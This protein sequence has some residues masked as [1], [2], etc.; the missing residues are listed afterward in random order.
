MD[1]LQID[2]PEDLPVSARRSEILEAIRDNQVVIIAGATGSGKTTQIPKMCLELGRTSI[3][4]TQPRRIAA[5]AVAERIAEELKVEL[6]SLVGYQVRFTDK[7]SAETK[8]KVMTDGILLNAMQ[9][10]RNLEQYDTVIIDE[11]HE[12]S[13]NIDFLLGYLKQLL[14]KR[15]DLKVIV[16]SAT[17]D[18][19]SF[20][21]H[22][23][24]APIIEVSGRTFPIEV[25][26]RPTAREV[27]D[28]TD[29]DEETTASDYID[30]LI[31]GLLELEREAEGDTLV[32]LSGESEIRDAQ[33]AIEGAIT[34]GR[35]KKGT[36]VLPLYGRLSADEQHRVFQPSKMVGLRRRVILATNVA[37][38][39][40]TIPNIK[41]VIDAGT[42]R[43]SRYSPKAKVQRLPIEAISQASANQRAGRSGRTSPGIVLRL[44]AEDDYNARPQ[45]TDPE[46]LRTNLASV[47]LQSANLGLGDIT[48]FPFIQPPD[49]RGVKDGLG[50]L[51]EL[52][53]I[54]DAKGKTIRL[55]A[56]GKNLARLPIEPRF[57]RMLLEA[58]E[59]NLVREVLVI[60]AGLTIQDPRERPLA[61][62]PQADLAHARFAD[63]TSDFLSLVNLWNYLEE[64][65]QKLSSSAF[66]RMCKA[67]YLNY[68]R[69]RE[70]HDLIRQLKSVAKPLGIVPGN[71]KVDPDGIHKALLAGLLSQIGLRQ[72]TEKK[73]ADKAKATD[74]KSK[75]SGE[76]LGSN[77]KKFVIFPGS[78]LAKKGPAAI[79]S[80]ELVE[81]SR[82]FARMNAA[83][84]PAWA[85][86]LA[87][88]LCK[89]SY[90]EPHWEKSQ[91]SVVAY[92]RVMLFGVPIVVSRRMQYSRIDAELCRDL[93]VR[94]ALVQGEWDAKLPF[95]RANR[96]LMKQL[97]AEAN[98]ARKPQHSPD[99]D[100]AFRFYMS[101][102]PSDVFSTRTF[103]GWWKRA[104]NDTPNLLTMTR[105]DL[106][107]AQIAAPDEHEHPTEWLH[108]GQQLKL[109]YRFDPAAIDD[110]VS[111]DVPLAVLAAINPDEFEWLVPG[112]RL[113]L[114]TE[115]IRSLPKAIRK[116]VVPA[117]DW[118]A[119][120]LAVLPAEPS[121]NI[122]VVLA[123]VLQQL[124]GTKVTAAD[125]DLSRLP[126]NLKMT[127]RPIDSAG[128]PLGLST[129][130]ATL[131]GKLAESGRGAVAQV[132]ERV[133]SPIE[134]DGITSW[135][136]DT[137][138]RSIESKHGSNIVRAFPALCV[139]K[140]ADAVAIRIFSTESEQAR[141]HRVGVVALLKKS[142]ASPAKYVEAHLSQ[143]EKLAIAGLPYPSFGAFI[144]DVIEAAA[145]LELGLV[146]PGGLIFT[147]TQFE[148]VRDAVSASIVERAFEVAT[149]VTKISGSL[150]DANKAISSVNGFDFLSVLAGEKAHI[151][152]L[153]QPKFVSGIGLARLPRLDVYLQAIKQRIE[154]MVDNPARDLVA[155]QEFE[156][157]LGLYVFAGGTLPLP[158]TAPEKLVSARW[159]LEEFRVS[160]FAQSLG[161]AETVSVQRIK[162][163]LS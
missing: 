140:N 107:G 111:V 147:R 77:G 27:H 137:L 92:E 48:Q 61:K 134:R 84:D 162:K 62:R 87:G 54:D 116:N 83:I 65:Q 97:E 67:E 70:W 127:Y 133:N 126:N 8:V 26:Y 145:D 141:H 122:A 2:Y 34:A 74:S 120:A 56:I 71:P 114:I 118:A 94:H 45:F 138:E 80:A 4:H 19:E 159:L 85:E 110:G 13:L 102:I 28:D 124:S 17:I 32:F 39:S 158:I 121:G 157:A 6:G 76:Y 132:I 41:Y 47:I 24:N 152:E 119:K 1:D 37:E 64:Q 22:F 46:I 73:V 99:E 43:I 29:P 49:P 117:A 30:G 101:R 155:A 58:K 91:G 3:A 42:A 50:L 79:M 163:A 143:T 81:T 33:E 96:A 90:S 38:T 15:P 161:A 16:T 142:I 149:L 109:R 52:G 18:P 146:E 31:K 125:F 115:M 113:E 12:R 144:D 63:P 11:A 78:T 104:K 103:E 105:E 66:R 153:M 75:G 82:L 9:R 106:L 10:H 55:T 68:L 93:F 148:Q 130:L 57:A 44:Y 98:R 20:S 5:R 108:N 7:V 25:R 112:M 131:Q 139:T 51:A 135:D 53:A 136:F 59:Q 69:V 100:D 129:E 21:Q 89:R 154:K 151:A 86:K 88:D 14:P 128:R 150:R 35:L 36:E 95:D 156:Q 60:V 72:L 160:L 23:G 123:K 40:L